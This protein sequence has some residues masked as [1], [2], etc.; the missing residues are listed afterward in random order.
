[1][2]AVLAVAL[3]GCGEDSP[4]PAPSRPAVSAEACRAYDDAIRLFA[5]DLDGQHARGF[6]VAGNGA[7][8]A[9]DVRRAAEGTD[10]PARRAFED[11]ATRIEALAVQGDAAPADLVTEDQPVRDAIAEVNRLCR[12]VGAPLWNIPSPPRG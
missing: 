7:P 10:G 6:L 4:S 1:M 3:A 2:T 5:H 9:R 8:A 11:T 12:E